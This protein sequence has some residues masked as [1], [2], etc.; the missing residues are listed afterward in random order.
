M[1]VQA[2]GNETGIF[3]RERKSGYSLLMA[4]ENTQR[5]SADEIEHRNLGPGG[6]K[7]RRAG[8]SWQVLKL[9][10]ILF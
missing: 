4:L 8:W 2:A 1:S 6:C 5:P 3:G 9:D 10:T 7:H